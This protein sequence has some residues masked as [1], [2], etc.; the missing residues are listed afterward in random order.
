MCD[1]FILDRVVQTA[2]SPRYVRVE[3][4][5]WKILNILQTTVWFTADLISE[6]I[7]RICPLGIAAQTRILYNHFI[8][9]Q[10]SQLGANASAC[11]SNPLFPVINSIITVFL[12]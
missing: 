1:N 6:L 5:D 7:F 2:F 10:L 9:F 3:L 12:V 4:F 8:R 11:I